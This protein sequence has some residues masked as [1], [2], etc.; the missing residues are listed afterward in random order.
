MNVKDINDTTP[1][2]EAAIYGGFTNKNY[3]IS[4][5]SSH[6]VHFWTIFRL[7]YEKVAKLLIENGA[8]TD[9]KDKQGNTP[10][11]FAADG[12]EERFYSFQP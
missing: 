4:D 9:A 10:L 5:I 7:G 2:H 3:T 12:G 1:L 8:S 6:L 11:H